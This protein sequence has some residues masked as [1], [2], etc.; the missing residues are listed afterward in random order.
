MVVEKLLSK[1]LEGINYSKGRGGKKPLFLVIHIIGLPGITAESAYAHFSNPNTEVSAHYIVKKNGE[2]WNLVKE[3]DTAFANGQIGKN[4][5]KANIA[6]MYYK[7]G[8]SLN[9]TSI[10]IENEGSEYVKIPE[11]QYQANAKLVRDIC[12][13]WNIPIDRLHVIRHDEIK[14]TKVC[15]GKI[16]V[17]KIVKFANTAIPIQPD[18]KVLTPVEAQKT[19]I[20]RILGLYQKLLA[21]LQYRQTLGIA[22]SPQW[23]EV[24]QKFLADHPICAVCLSSAKLEVHHIK[25]LY[26]HGKEG[27]LDENNLIVLCRKDHLLFGHLNSFYSENPDV[28]KD[29]IYYKSKILNRP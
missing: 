28:E 25:S 5:P 27:E 21:L 8:I 12:V 20:V 9:A 10:S 15:C 13:R 1:S 4:F 2:V 6:A 14:D 29:A 7:L 23:R 18:I 3:E 16:D 17:D 22:R 11:I 24:R 26:L 19:L